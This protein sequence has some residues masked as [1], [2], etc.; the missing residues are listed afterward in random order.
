M[1]ASIP[2]TFCLCSFR[3]DQESPGSFLKHERLA[4]MDVDCSVGYNQ[5]SCE[6]AMAV[7]RLTPCCHSP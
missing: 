5:S 2:D 7:G 4:W 6:P 1:R 3:R